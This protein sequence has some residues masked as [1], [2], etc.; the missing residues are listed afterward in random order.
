MLAQNADATA[1]Q[2]VKCRN[3]TELSNYIWQLKDLNI[4]PWEIFE[5]KRFHGKSQQ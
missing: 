4:T 1:D 3:S 5:K 2:G